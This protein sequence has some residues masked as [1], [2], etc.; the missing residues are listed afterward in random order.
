MKT[1]YKYSTLVRQYIYVFRGNTHTNNHVKQCFK[2]TAP[3]V[4]SFLIELHMEIRQPNKNL[5]SVHFM[6]NHR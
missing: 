1:P 5:S 4:C 2:R 3:M 6:K